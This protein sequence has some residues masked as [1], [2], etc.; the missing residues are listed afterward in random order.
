M[1]KRVT[2]EHVFRHSYGQLVALLT[3]RFGIEFIDN[4]EDAV[5]WS[6]A[7]AIEFWPK[8]NTPENPTAWLY[9]VAYRHLLSELSATK[10][11][12][13]L[14]TEHQSQMGSHVLEE[15]EAPLSGEID[16]SLLRMLFIACDEA[17]P[18]ESQLVFTLKSLCG[19]NIR[20]IALRLFISEANVYK[21]F[22]RA[23]KH[24]QNHVQHLNTLNDAEMKVRLPAIYRVLYLVFTEGYLSSHADRAIR[25]DLCEEAIRLVN[26]LIDSHVG[27][28]PESYALAALMY[29][30]LA[31]INAREDEGG[32]LLLLEHQDRTKWDKQLIT[33]GLNYLEQ[34][35]QGEIISRYHIEAGIAAEHCLASSFQQTRWEK[36]IRSY[37]CLERIFPSPFHVLNRAIALAQWK[38]PQAGLAVLLSANMPSWLDRT[39]HWYAVLADLQFRCGE[40]SCADKNATLAINSAPTEHIKQLLRK[41]LIK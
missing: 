2:I 17:I 20:E 38:T 1:N 14:I 33:L 31:R 3:R 21:R 41:R 22:S 9:Q 40:T 39:Y 26:I 35:A 32:T 16:D 36:I 4:I 30:H 15:T 8:T 29:F 37:E 34:S 6:M 12:M 27:N 19:F 18:I 13:S 10:R 7:Q 25:Q 24:L 5:Q 23:K 11:K 28:A